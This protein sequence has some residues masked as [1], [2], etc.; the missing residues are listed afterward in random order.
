MENFTSIDPHSGV[1]LAEYPAADKTQIQSTIEHSAFAY[2]HWKQMH[3]AE[4]SVLIGK[5]GAVLL[6]HKKAYAK[7]IT[8]EMGKVLYEAEAEVEKCAALCAWYAAHAEELLQDQK[9][10][11]AP[12]HA[13]LHIEPVGIVLG[14][15]PWNFPF[16]QV[17]R[18]AVPALLTGNTVL[19]KHAPNVCGCARILQDIFLEAGLPS[20]VFTSLLIA[21]DDVEM[22]IAHPD[23]QG[24]SF[25]GSDKAGALVAALAGKYIKRS[26]I[27]LGG[28]DPFIVL[29]DADMTQAV[30]TAVRSRYQNAGQ[31]CIAAKRFFIEEKIYSTFMQAFVQGVERLVMGDPMERGTHVGP[32]ARPDLAEK[33]SDQVDR[34]VRAGAKIVTGCSRDHS[35]I[36]PGILEAVQTD[37]PAFCEELFGPVAAVMQVRDA[38]EAISLANRSKYG[39][40]ATIFTADQEKALYIAK[41]LNTGTVSINALMHSDPALPFGGV[42]HSGYGKE[43]GAAGLFSFANVK[44]IGR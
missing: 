34:S 27:E 37:Q 12:D 2:K 3:V 24:V 23:V 29:Q 30:K 8:M 7:L 15:M 35:Y 21:V 14:I 18:Y 28:S 1:V 19:L 16:W 13:I 11:F 6:E 4:R 32:L 17:F 25:T 36:T 38:E 44:L 20:H 5:V 39:L 10:K 40:G 43:L 22:V 31:S 33:I 9:P 41:Q 42:K 26:V